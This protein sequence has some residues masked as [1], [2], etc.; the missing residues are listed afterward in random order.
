LQRNGAPGKIDVTVNSYEAGIFSAER[1]GGY[2]GRLLLIS[3]GG[4]YP[5]MNEQD[6]PLRAAGGIKAGSGKALFPH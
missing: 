4:D 3:I 5:L 2:C 1:P 6:S